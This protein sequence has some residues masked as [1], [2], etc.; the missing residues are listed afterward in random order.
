MCCPVAFTGVSEQHIT[1]IFTA[2]KHAKLSAL[3]AACDFLDTSFT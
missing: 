1:S 2:E 3:L